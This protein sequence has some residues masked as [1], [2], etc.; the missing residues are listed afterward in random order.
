MLAVLRFATSVMDYIMIGKNK[1]Y[2]YFTADKK[3]E[4]V[5]CYLQNYVTN[6]MLL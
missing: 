5:F 4:Y 3:T 2:W 6:F 1:M